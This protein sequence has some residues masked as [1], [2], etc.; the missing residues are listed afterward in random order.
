MSMAA[1]RTAIEELAANVLETCFKNVDQAT[2]ENA[3]NRL[4]DVVGCLIGGANAAGNL[5]LVNL[6]KNWGG[7]EE[8]TIFVHGG[9][10]PAHNSAM[11]NSIIARSFD[12]EAL[13]S[14]VEGQ[15]I[16]SHVSGTTIMTALT[17]SDMKGVDGKELL[18]T[19]LVGD[20]VAARLLAASGFGFTPGW[21]CIGTVNMMGA[22][23]IAG[24]L[25]SLNKVQMR[26]A[27]GIVLNQL[28]ASFQSIWDGTTSFKLHQGISARNG[29]F[30]AEL[31]KVGWTGPD[32]ALF[33]KF[34]YF[35]LYTEGCMSPEILTKDL[36]KI[37][38]SDATFKPYPCCR[39][40]HGPID[41]AL[42]L[43]R[44]HDIQADNIDSV[45]LYVPREGLEGFLGQ[46]FKI[47][48]FP[49]ACGVFNYKYTLANA[50]LRKG[51]TPEHFSEDAIR[52]PQVN[53]LI[54]K[55]ELAELQEAKT[56]LSARVQV[57][58]EDGQVFTETTVAPKGS[59]VTN[60][61]SREEIKAKFRAN[62]DFSKTLTK[63][64]TEKLLGILEKTDELDNVNRIGELL[65]P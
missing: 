40:T 19:F 20:D 9:K 23:A 63:E 52:D 37:Y 34:G 4:I 13:S 15:S 6:I 54:G 46:E 8:A 43:V 22:T 41:C 64:N 55:I 2:V 16:P 57:K 49:H 12:F 14:F 32:D 21:D 33:S 26:N 3:I 11:V 62:V 48:D 28:A 35:H 30:S 51:V 50:L 27:F 7:K 42:A 24:R 44:K 18:T 53:N 36:G 17:L 58:M 38:Y 10:V 45:I 47:G 25:L 31:A 60:P 59:P 1:K 5:E 61:M 29:I 65:V 56:G 39:G